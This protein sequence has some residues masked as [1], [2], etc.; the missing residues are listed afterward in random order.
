MPANTQVSYQYVR[1]EPDGTY[2]Y[3]KTN[4]TLTTGGCGSD[5]QSTHDIITTDSPPHSSSSNKRD[6]MAP[7]TQLEKRQSSGPGSMLGLP[8]RNLIDPAYKINNAAGS[9]SNKTLDTELT[10]YGGWKE[11]DTHNLYGAMMSAASC[12]AML[13][14]RPTLRPMVITRSTFAG[15][16]RQVGHWLGDNVADWEHYL[17]S[18]KGILDFGALFQ[19][20]MVGSDVCGF[21]G[22]TNE[23][24]CARWAT[25][26]DFSPF[27]RN[28]G[29]RSA[30]PHEFYR[31]P[32]VAQAAR[33]AIIIRYQL[34]DYIYT[35]LYEQN[36]TG[37]PI[38]HPM[39]FAYPHDP[40]C[41]TLQH[42]YLYGPGIMVAPVTTENSTTAQI[43]LPD[44]VFYDFY[45]H[46]T[47]HG[48]G[49]TITKEVEYTSIPLY[50]KGGSI[51]AQRSKSANTTTELRKVN[52]AIVIAPGL[53]GSASGSLY[54]DDGVSVE[55]QSTSYIQFHYSN[56]G[57]FSMTG[58]FGYDSGVSIESVTVLGSNSSSKSNSGT[59]GDELQKA[60]VQKSIPLT[61]PFEM[62]V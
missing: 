56:D 34:L 22:V 35:A 57:H 60:R 49:S 55:Q 12:K 39:F 31:W 13:S 62:N 30:P 20:P 54:L 38:M 28:L 59:C 2:V 43:Y 14:R 23:L 10:H 44:D 15:S 53:D 58:S 33:N 25:L 32:L 7:A 19:V 1:A 11:Y 45:T 16:G 26:G 29:S 51:I 18:I 21:S 50:Y 8:D 47:V 52:F 4:R 5:N 36:Q 37:I 42:Q 27:Y 61:G 9:L 40:N 41:S 48:Q 6:L 46:E 17:F 24:L 3:E